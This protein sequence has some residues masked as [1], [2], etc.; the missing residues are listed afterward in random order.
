MVGLPL[1]DTPRP[2][3][4]GGTLWTPAWGTVASMVARTIPLAPFLEGRGDNKE[5]KKVYGGTSS[6]PP[7]SGVAPLWTPPAMVG[8]PLGDTPRPLPGGGTLWT[9]AWGT[10]ASMVARTIPLAPFLEGRGDNKEKKKVYGGTSSRPPASGAVPLWTPPAMVGLPLGDTPRP[11]PGGG[12]LWTPAWGTVASMVARTIPLAPFLEGRGDN[13]EKKKVYGGT[14]S[15]PPAS[16]AVPLWTPPWARGTP[17]DHCQRGGAPLDSPL[18]AR[19]SS[20]P[21]AKGAVP[22]W[23]PRLRGRP[24]LDSRFEAVDVLIRAGVARFGS[25]SIIHPQSGVGGPAIPGCG[26]RSLGRWAGSRRC[27]G[28]AADGTPAP[29]HAVRSRARTCSPCRSPCPA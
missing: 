5:K 16:G 2:L 10:V 7:A 13:K 6:I 1:G 12:T 29:R 27:P 28:A 23:T 19:D 15:R 8:L 25:G 14:S 3:P 21:P 4:G 20:R 22:L 9:P 24:P 18:G 11:L 17:P 26:P